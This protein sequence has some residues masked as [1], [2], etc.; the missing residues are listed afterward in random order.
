MIEVTFGASSRNLR[1]L[2]TVRVL[3]PLKSLN[4]MPGIKK[5]VETLVDALPNFFNVSVFLIFIFV[6]FAI[7]GLHQYG[8]SFFN[9]CRYNPEPEEPGVSWAIVEEYYRPCTKNGLGRYKCK[10]FRNK[11]DI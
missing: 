1:T 8:G 10:L 11:F 5:H 9:R 7:L 3:R 2:R 4:A 6:L